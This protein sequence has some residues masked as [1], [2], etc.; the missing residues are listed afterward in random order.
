ME[1]HF[2]E[3]EKELVRHLQDDLP[4]TPAPYAEIAAEV[5]MGEAEVLKKVRQWQEDGTIRRLGAM[6]R[7]QRLGYNANAMSAWDVPDARVEEV[8]EALADASEV[9]HCYER[10]RAD[11]W[12]YNVFAMIHAGTDE[13][14]LQVAESLARQVGIDSFELLFSTREFK[15]ISMSYF[16]E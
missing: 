4:L 9:S 10:P 14:C 6:V 8:G 1:R 11:G 15:K 5:G 16:M 7:H 3:Q 13:E 2:T 12:K